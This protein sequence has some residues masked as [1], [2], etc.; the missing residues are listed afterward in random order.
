MLSRP[1]MVGINALCSPCGVSRSCVARSAHHLYIV[2]SWQNL[3]FFHALPSGAKLARRS[4]A[5]CLSSS[6]RIIILVSFRWLALSAAVCNTR[7]LPLC[8]THNV[9]VCSYRDIHCIVRPS[10]CCR[11]RSWLEQR[12]HRLIRHG[13]VYVFEYLHIGKFISQAV[14]IGRHS[15]ASFQGAFTLMDIMIV[16]TIFVVDRFQHLSL[17]PQSSWAMVF[18]LCSRSVSSINVRCI[19]RGTR[20]RTIIM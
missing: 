5:Y 11:C 10:N 1:S 8:P 18:G 14:F 17:R 19:A 3:S 2:V 16:F 20:Q 4:E 13:N 15:L 6:C 9:L 7:W 12:C